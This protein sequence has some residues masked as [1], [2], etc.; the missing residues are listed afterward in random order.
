MVASDSKSLNDLQCTVVYEDDAIVAI[1][2]PS[3]L[4]SVQLGGSDSA[5]VADWLLARYPILEKVGDKPGD[6][7]LI[8]RLDFETSGIMVAA[9]TKSAWANLKDQME[10]STINKSYLIL[11]EGQPTQE[12]VMNTWIGSRYRGSKKVTVYDTSHKRTL[13]AK[14]SFRLLKYFAENNCALIQARA[15]AARRHQVRAHAAHAGFPLIG[16]K[17]YGAKSALSN[18]IDDSVPDL[19]PFFLHARDIQLTHPSAKSPIKLEAPAPAWAKI[20]LNT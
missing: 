3:L 12:F 13:P 20:L 14:T 6:A 5:S 11:V 18:C 15:S 16:D 10:H 2:K 9:L 17:L 1:N 4:H 19:P 7:G 8:Q